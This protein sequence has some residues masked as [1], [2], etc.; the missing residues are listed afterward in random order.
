VGRT[1]QEKDV[2]DDHRQR[3]YDA[4]EQ[5]CRQLEHAAAGARLVPVAGSTVV[6]PL[7]VRFGTLDAAADYVER[8]RTGSAFRTRFPRAAAAPLQVRARRGGR[9]AHYEAPG[10][11]ALHDPA[12]GPAWALRELVVLHEI[13]HHAFHHEELPGPLHGP[14]FTG[15]LVGLVGE[16]LGPEAA[17]LL[18]AAYAE[19]GVP[20]DDAAGSR[21]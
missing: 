2:R 6:A 16:V 1:G 5:V 15:A 3:V 18:R 9:A 7:E 8:V 4:E 17:L 13:A 12:A 10:T 20:V 11:I 19:H 21:A 14:A